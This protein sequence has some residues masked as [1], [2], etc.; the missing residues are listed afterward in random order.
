MSGAEKL[1]IKPEKETPNT[2]YNTHDCHA[3]AWQQKEGIRMPDKERQQ[4]MEQEWADRIPEMPDRD[5]E[6]GSQDEA[7]EPV[8]R[9]GSAKN[10]CWKEE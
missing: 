8:Y 9:D 4:K 10:E 5:G 6:D 2:M 1:Q 3:W 7:W